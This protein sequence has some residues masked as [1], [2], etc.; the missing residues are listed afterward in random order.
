M[1]R[2]A[3]RG[4]EGKAGADPESG[5]EAR[6]RT[7]PRCSERLHPHSLRSRRVQVEP[8]DWIVRRGLPRYQKK[9]P[10]KLSASQRL[11]SGRI[12]EV[13]VKDVIDL[14]VREVERSR[15]VGAYQ[16][17]LQPLPRL[18]HNRLIFKKIDGLK[19]QF[20][21]G[22]VPLDGEALEV[23]CTARPECQS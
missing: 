22:R 7:F 21:D 15:L 1:L 23:A 8:A 11:M 20:P 19:D 17:Q 13:G 10:E 12:D 6:R 9:I 3:R 5:S 4:V 2:V 14:L 16:G 18:R